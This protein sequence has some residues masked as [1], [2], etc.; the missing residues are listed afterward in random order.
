MSDQ[1]VTCTQPFT[2]PVL[3]I[4]APSSLRTQK[5]TFQVPAPGTTDAAAANVRWSGYTHEIVA[6]RPATKLVIAPPV[7]A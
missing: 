2:E 1:F 7:L 4:A 5:P 6:E 3:L